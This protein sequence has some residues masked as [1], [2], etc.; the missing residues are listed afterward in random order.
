MSEA[1]LRDALWCIANWDYEYEEEAVGDMREDDGLGG[2]RHLFDPLGLRR[3][4]PAI[5]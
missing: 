1:I 2:R 3:W 5:P 4:N